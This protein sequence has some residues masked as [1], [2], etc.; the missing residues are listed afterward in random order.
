MMYIPRAH[1][2]DSLDGESQP[3]PRLIILPSPFTFSR[4]KSGT[5]EKKNGRKSC[6][7]GKKSYICSVKQQ[8]THTLKMRTKILI[9]TILTYILVIPVQGQIEQKKHSPDVAGNR[10]LIRDYRDSITI[11]YVEAKDGKKYFIREVPGLSTAQAALIPD[12]ITVNDMDV[13]SEYLYFCGTY[14]K[15]GRTDGIVGLFNI[16]NLYYWGQPYYITRLDWAING[17]E[18]ARMPIPIKVGN[19]SYAGTSGIQVPIVGEIEVEDYFGNITTQTGICAAHIDNLLLTWSYCYY[20][21]IDPDIVFTDIARTDNTHVAVGRHASH[22][23]TLARVFGST[24]PFLY[25]IPG[26]GIY[27]ITDS[28]TEG[29]VLT[30]AIE[31]NEIALSNYYQGNATAGITVKKFDVFSPSTQVSVMLQQSISP[32]VPS[33]WKLHEIQY[34]SNH[35]KIYVLQDMDYPVSTSVAAT[36]CEFDLTTPLPLGLFTIP[37]YPATGMGTW[38]D[39]GFQIV[40]DDL[41]MLTYM[42]KK[43][44]EYSSCKQTT[45]EGLSVYTVPIPLVPIVEG[46]TQIPQVPPDTL[47]VRVININFVED[48]NIANVIEP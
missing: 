31:G 22:S 37:G 43:G 12:G 38:S 44:W 2:W 48:C 5:K 21:S 9:L 24:F 34:D 16:P 23:T 8:R 13:F 40:G 17:Y 35:K 20:Y 25:T 33:S 14:R 41:G 18:K 26:N 36:V 4:G 28:V 30:T 15:N 11:S 10:A 45:E 27:E 29:I 3:R 6:H 19:T 7:I 47:S 42:R 46:L 1:W 32:F 39:E